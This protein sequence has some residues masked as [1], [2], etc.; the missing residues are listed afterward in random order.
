MCFFLISFFFRIMKDYETIHEYR[1][2]S[3][4]EDKN[5]EKNIQWIVICKTEIY[6]NSGQLALSVSAFSHLSKSVTPTIWELSNRYIR[7]GL[8][9]EV[10]T[11]L[12]GI[13]EAIEGRPMG[14]VSPNCRNFWKMCHWTNFEKYP[15]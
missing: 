9:F 5:F 12:M 2:L 13:R 7:Y 3:F 10:R 6:Y 1:M 14:F 4:K 11:Y 8:V 15:I